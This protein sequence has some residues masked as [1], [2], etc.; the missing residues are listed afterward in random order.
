MN[1]AKSG[2]KLVHVVPHV[3]SLVQATGWYDAAI[4]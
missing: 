3:A 4:C 1:E 2:I